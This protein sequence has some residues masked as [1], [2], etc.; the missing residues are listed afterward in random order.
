M[1]GKHFRP[2]DT[3]AV[4]LCI[5]EAEL[6]SH[7]ELVLVIRR[8]SGN[9]RD[10]DY[11]F[12][13]ALAFL[14]LLVKL[15]SAWEFDPLS[16][17]LPIAAVFFAGA[18]ASHRLGARRFL[19]RR[20]RK[21]RQVR[22]AARA[23]FF[24]RGVYRTKRQNGVLLYCSVLE[25]HAELIPD[26]LVRDALGDKRLDELS[27][28]LVVAGRSAAGL[29]E[30]L[31]SLGVELG[32]ALPAPPPGAAQENELDDTPELETGEDS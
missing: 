25:R 1:W 23:A 13:G 20:A 4:A 9:Y 27:D 21:I 26:R 32:R 12:G 16:I 24:E 7:A 14:L 29:A 31:R 6:R 3:R 2:E 5:H 22:A 15:F 8:S 10:L 17:P 11:L 18:W 30:F 19:A 28:A